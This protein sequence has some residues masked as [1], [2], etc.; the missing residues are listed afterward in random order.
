MLSLKIK[1][2]FP[3]APVFVCFCQLAPLVKW[4]W[5]AHISCNAGSALEG[6]PELGRRMRSIAT[7]GVCLAQTLGPSMALFNSFQIFSWAQRKLYPS[8]QDSRS[9]QDNSMQG[10]FKV[11]NSVEGFDLDQWAAGTAFQCFWS[12]HK[13]ASQANGDRRTT[14]AEGK[15][16]WHHTVLICTWVDKPTRTEKWVAWTNCKSQPLLTSEALTMTTTCTWGRVCPGKASW[17]Q[18]ASTGRMAPVSS[19]A[20]KRWF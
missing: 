1:L 10:V 12:V 17:I 20:A 3:K 15:K 8:Y 18:L 9:N 4:C 16:T 7:I 19:R 2:S 6:R 5:A 14:R 13:R 11:E